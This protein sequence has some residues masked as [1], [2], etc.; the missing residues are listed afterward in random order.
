M[1]ILT[2]VC[3]CPHSSYPETAM[4]CRHV[5]IVNVVDTEVVAGRDLESQLA[6]E[7]KENNEILGDGEWLNG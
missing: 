3:P 1:H 4:T 2:R 7:R 6:S 5:E